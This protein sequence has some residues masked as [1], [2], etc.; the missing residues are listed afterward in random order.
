MSWEVRF[1][2]HGDTVEGFLFGIR[3]GRAGWVRLIEST[4]GTNW[5]IV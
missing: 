3:Q 4:Q 1:G 5:F 2:V